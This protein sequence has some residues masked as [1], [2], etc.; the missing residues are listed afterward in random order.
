M[1]LISPVFIGSGRTTKTIVQALTNK[2][3][4]LSSVLVC[5]TSTEIL[6]ALKKQYRPYPA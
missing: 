1:E 5:D 3:I 2:Q 4:E 6:N